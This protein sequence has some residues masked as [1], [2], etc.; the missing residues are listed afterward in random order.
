MVFVCLVRAMNENQTTCGMTSLR[1]VRKEGSLD[2]RQGI[3][4][5]NTE[6]RL[7]LSGGRDRDKKSRQMNCSNGKQNFVHCY[8]TRND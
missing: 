3:C 7:K 2:A 8:K 1:V 4:I 5:F 6:E